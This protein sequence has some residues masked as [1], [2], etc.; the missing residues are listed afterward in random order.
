VS[1]DKLR[2]TGFADSR[3]ILP[4]AIAESAS[5]VVDFKGDMGRDGAENSADEVEVTI[6][7]VNPEI[8]PASGLYEIRAE[9]DNHDQKMYSGL[10]SI[11]KL[12]RKK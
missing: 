5:L 8:D 10:K 2:F 4:S 11:L 12:R 3:E 6:T 9:V 7:F 1:T